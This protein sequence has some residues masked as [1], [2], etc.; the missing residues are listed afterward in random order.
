MTSTKG[1]SF[2][3]KGGRGGGDDRGQSSITFNNDIGRAK[4]ASIVVRRD[5]CHLAAQNWQ[6]PITMTAPAQCTVSR[7]LPRKPRT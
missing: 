7:S 1:S 3:Q 4:H 5:T 6:L 2:A